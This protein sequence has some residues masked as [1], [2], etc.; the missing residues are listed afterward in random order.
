MLLTIPVFTWA[1]LAC[2]LGIRRFH[3]P[4][5]AIAGTGYLS[6]VASFLLFLGVAG[7]LALP[8]L[9]AALGLTLFGAICVVGYAFTY[10]EKMKAL[11]I[12]PRRILGLQGRQ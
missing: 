9:F 4:P 3:Y 1:G 2:F 11:G 6:W 7:P 10:N 12:T 8:R 5:L